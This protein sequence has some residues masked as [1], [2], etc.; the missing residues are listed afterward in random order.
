M[1]RPLICCLIF[2]SVIALSACGGG[3]SLPS[4]PGIGSSLESAADSNDGMPTPPL[5]LTLPERVAPP[6]DPLEMDASDAVSALP[7]DGILLFAQDGRRRMLREL[8]LTLEREQTRE[9]IRLLIR[10]TE[11]CTLPSNLLLYLR[12]DP[13]RFNPRSVEFAE[14]IFPRDAHLQLA[15]LDQYAHI[16]FAVAAL[17]GA[18]RVRIRQRT[19]LAYIELELAPQTVLRRASAAPTGDS[20]MVDVSV[21][22]VGERARVVF[23]ER[24]LGDFDLNGKVEIADITQ[25]AMHY[26]KHL[27]FVQ[28][29]VIDGSG[30]DKVDIADITQLAMNYG[31]TLSGYDIE[32]AFTPEGGAEGG[33]ERLEN[34]SEPGDPT[35]TRPFISLPQ[36]WPEYDYL[37][38]DVGYGTYKVRVGAIGDS[39][40]DVGAVSLPQQV[41]IVNLPPAPPSTFYVSASDRTSV[42]LTWSPSIATD[43]AGYNVYITEDAA[44]DELADYMKV[45]T[46][47]LG[48]TETEYTATDL[49]PTTDYWFVIEAMDD[50][51]LPSLENAVLAT[52]A[53]AT[54]V[55]TPEVVIGVESGDHYEMQ[56]IDFTGDDSTSPDGAELVH[57][58]WD[59]DD[60]TEPED[61]PPPGTTTHTFETPNPTG[62]TVTLTIEDEYGAEGMA[63]VVV[64]V[65]ALR[66]DVLVVYNLNSADDLEI[67]DYYASPETGRGIHPD[68]VHG[69]DL[70]MNQEI[71]RDDY[72]LT[73]R[74]TLI[75]HLDSTG[76]KDEVLYIVTTKDVPLQI[77][78]A[79]PTDPPPPDE[80]PKEWKN[81]YNWTNTRRACVDSELTLLYQDA[82]GAYDTLSWKE[83]PYYGHNSS[84]PLDK[85]VPAESQPWQPGH[86]TVNEQ[87]EEVYHWPGDTYTLDYLVTRLSGWYKEDVLA[88]IDRGIAAENTPIPEYVVIFDDANKPYD[89]MNDTTADGTES[90]VDVFQ[91][92]GLS[93]F[94]DT[95]QI[96]P[97]NEGLEIFA[98]TLTDYGFDPNVVIG[99]C[100]HGVHAQ[101]PDRPRYIIEDL[102][103][104]YLPGALFMSY[105]SHNG[106]QFRGDPLTHDGHGQVADWIYMGGTGAIGNVYEPLSS[107]CGD[108]SIL[109][110]EY[111]NCGR[112]LAEACYKS[113]RFV[114]WQEVVLGDPLCKL[115]V[116]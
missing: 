107:A 55:V 72:N 35:L 44:A 26:G 38:P 34:A 83:N 89:M 47:L 82:Q 29:P 54:T 60:G 98:S 105:E 42:T 17:P 24:N 41:V 63:Q 81:A 64:P 109:F 14:D 104:G 93:F 10:A 4:S 12:F 28:T 32:L 50:K 85:G 73:I 19:I 27:E 37:L 78:T 62:F 30:N 33:F 115:N 25:I 8:P 21:K 87:E 90:A 68:Y 77:G 113:M 13:E 74:D 71:S 67:A 20:N 2:L 57:F 108:E 52:K 16:P 100:S 110:A 116:Q 94:A 75:D 99:Y 49:T 6:V 18:E 96:D 1:K 46:E 59:W 23:Y 43:L 102:N 39:P 114:S 86:F 111:V 53:H 112:N 9:C 95:V 97:P 79:G 84:N 66:R 88:M 48:P 5:P 22:I 103:F 92:L 11:D 45:N 106:R 91:R 101:D 65:L 56:E 61:V 69:M 36:G 76:Q 70:S 31:N 58:T 80:W 40:S 51:D 7:D 15:V 3:G